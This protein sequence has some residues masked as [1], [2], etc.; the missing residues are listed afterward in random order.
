[1]RER[2]GTGTAAQNESSYVIAIPPCVWGSP[3][4]GLLPPP[5]IHLDSN[6]ST[7]KRANS[8][9]GHWGTMALWQMRGAYIRKE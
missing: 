9:N 5:V 7:V 6:L 3:E 2:Y 4:E 1:M 8:T